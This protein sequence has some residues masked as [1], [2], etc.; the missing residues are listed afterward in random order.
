[1]IALAGQATLAQNND[2][3]AKVVSNPSHFV[4]SRYIDF[5]SA[6]SIGTYWVFHF[7]LESMFACTCVKTFVV[8]IRFEGTVEFCKYFNLAWSECKAHVERSEPFTSYKA[9]LQLLDAEI[10]KL[11]A[12]ES[13]LVNVKMK[14][15][16]CAVAADSLLADSACEMHQL[17]A[18]HLSFLANQVQMY[19]EVDIFGAVRH[20]KKVETTFGYNSG[21]LLPFLVGSLAADVHLRYF[22]LGSCFY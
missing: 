20:V 22:L 8:W 12:A 21:C 17:S 13:I 10:V 5:D 14:L 4:H 16:E 3:Q 9:L 15:G 18:A 6:C 7:P 19:I 1:M 11:Q 2:S